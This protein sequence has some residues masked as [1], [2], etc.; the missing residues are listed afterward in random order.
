MSRFWEVI[1]KTCA[2]WKSNRSL[3]MSKILFGKNRAAGAQCVPFA[4]LPRSPQGNYFMEVK[5]KMQTRCKEQ[6]A[7][8][9]GHTWKSLRNSKSH[10]SITQTLE[11]IICDWIAR[12]AV[13]GLKVQASKHMSFSAP[14]LR[15]TTMTLGFPLSTFL[16]RESKKSRILY[17]KCRIDMLILRRTVLCKLRGSTYLPWLFGACLNVLPWWQLQMLWKMSNE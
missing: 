8:V 9:C 12:T 17:C 13:K 1:R 5:T 2:L 7:Y 10:I 14:T 16:V 6:A 3:L 11:V 15:N 4:I